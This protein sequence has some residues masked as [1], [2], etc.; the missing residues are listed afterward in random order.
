MEPLANYSIKYT[1]RIKNLKTLSICWTIR[2]RS[3][4]DTSPREKKIQKL[5]EQANDMDQ[6]LRIS[7]NITHI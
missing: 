7:I 1:H 5:N 3:I 2:L 6:D 4:K